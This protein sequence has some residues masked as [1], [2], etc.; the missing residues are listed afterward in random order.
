MWVVDRTWKLTI[1]A[2]QNRIL[3]VIIYQ[4]VC[5]YDYLKTVAQPRAETRSFVPNSGHRYTVSSLHYTDTAVINSLRINV[6]A[7][8]LAENLLA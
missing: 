7:N 1:L 4:E 3:V 2:D 6:T 5:Q 8:H